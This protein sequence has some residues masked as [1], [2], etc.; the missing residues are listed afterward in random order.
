M[1]HKISAVLLFLLVPAAMIACILLQS[2]QTALL[3]TLILL[4]ALTPFFLAFERQKP[5]PRDFM[6]VVVL[7]ALSVTGRLLFAALPNFKPVSAIVILAGVCFGRQSGFL[8]GA[9]SALVSNLFFGQGPW[10]PWQMYAWGLMGYVAGALASTKLFRRP[11]V[12]LLYGFL[13]SF[14]YGFLM[15]SWMLFSFVHPVTWQAALATYGAALAFD[16]AHA[17]STVAFLSVTLLPWQKELR[18]I[19]QKYGVREL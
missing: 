2:P 15:N 16:A 13:A 8:T 1:Q 6:P 7:T 19:R 18:R 12:V 10:T 5:R 11:W 3:S 9:L 14:G 4:A 17:V